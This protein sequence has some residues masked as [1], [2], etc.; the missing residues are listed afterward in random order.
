MIPYVQRKR[1]HLD[2]SQGRPS[3]LEGLNFLGHA[4]IDDIDYVYMNDSEEGFVYSEEGLYD[5]ELSTLYLDTG[6]SVVSYRKT[7]DRV[8]ILSSTAPLESPICFP[9]L[10]NLAKV[11][12]T[13]QS[14]KLSI[15]PSSIHACQPLDPESF[16]SKGKF[17]CPLIVLSSSGNFI[18]FQRNM[19]FDGIVDIKETNRVANE[20][21]KSYTNPYYIQ[22]LLPNQCL[23]YFAI[24]TVGELQDTLQE[25]HRVIASNV[26][27]EDIFGK[28]LAPFIFYDKH[29]MFICRYIE[30]IEN[31]IITP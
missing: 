25:W 11:E 2:F 5:F 20:T 26:P 23:C 27:G 6:I 16:Y 22:M 4:R 30:S 14:A 9:L 7:E 13:K 29:Q 18:V 28:A 19:P 24:E 17:G 3:A 1:A 12:S 15:T 31:M 8:D 10:C 21:V